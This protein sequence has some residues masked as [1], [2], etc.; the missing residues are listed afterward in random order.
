MLTN[1]D[2][3]LQALSL[4]IRFNLGC[5]YDKLNQVA[6][7]SNIYKLIIKEEPGYVDAYLRLAI[8]AKQ[9][10]SLKRQHDYIDMAKKCNEQMASQNIPVN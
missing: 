4:T 2:P 1:G 5:L 9:R 3:K 7:A 8:Q 10:G 6:E